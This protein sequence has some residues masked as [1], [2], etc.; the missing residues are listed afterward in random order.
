MDF[1]RNKLDFLLVCVFMRL[2]I[3]SA[4]CVASSNRTPGFFFFPSSHLSVTV[5]PYSPVFLDG[6]QPQACDSAGQPLEDPIELQHKQDAIRER[7]EAQSLQEQA[8][9]TA[10]GYAGGS[11]EV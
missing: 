8:R 3:I 2:K 9:H 10:Q 1:T 7:R 4:P 6:W 11:D 5:P